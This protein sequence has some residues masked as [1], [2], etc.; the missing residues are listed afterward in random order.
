MTVV[1]KTWLQRDVR[2]RVAALLMLVWALALI[3]YPRVETLLAPLVV[4]GVGLGLDGLV[5]RLRGRRDFPSSALVTSLLVGLILPPD[6]L[7]A[8]VLAVVLA[9]VSK[10]VFWKGRHWFN[11]AAFGIVV[12]GL[13][14]S[15][16]AGWWAVAWSWVPPV[17]IVIGMVWILQRLRRIWLPLTFLAA[18][19]AWVSLARGDLQA[20]PGI[21]VDGTVALFAFVMLPEPIT[22]PA[23]GGWKYCFG[24]LVVLTAIGLS[25]L[26]RLAVP[27]FD[28]LL[29]SLLVANCFVGITRQL[30]RPTDST[31]SQPLA[32]PTSPSP[33]ND[34]VA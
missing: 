13:L 4:V 14:T 2:H 11:P 9:L 27:P 10:H 30:T 12:T 3:P 20:L 33:Q 32:P 6:K 34:Q 19:A 15:V 8:A 28:L 21:A 18:Y 16:Q 25:S 17:M 22:S 29:S 5:H 26:W 23:T 1:L 31:Q 7:P 24:P